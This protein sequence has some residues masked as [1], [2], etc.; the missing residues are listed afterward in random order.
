MHKDL[1]NQQHDLEAMRR[2]LQQKV[3]KLYTLRIE[4]A[5]G[6]PIV[7]L[8]P[9]DKLLLVGVK[10]SVARYP[11]MLMVEFLTPSGKIVELGTEGRPNY[12]RTVFKDLL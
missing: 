2:L 8:Y 4:R 7:Y 12:I 3:G 6:Y 1:V 10:P 11:T 9:E 5:V